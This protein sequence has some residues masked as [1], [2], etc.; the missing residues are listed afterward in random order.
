MR[1]PKQASRCSRRSD[2]FSLV[3]LLVV[4]TVIAILAALILAAGNGVFA[5]GKRSRAAGEISAMSSAA[6][7]YKNDNAVYPQS[8]G[9]LTTNSP[10]TTFDGATSGDEYQI[11]SGLLYLALTGQTNFITPPLP[12]VKIYMSFKVNQI[13]NPSGT[14]TTYSYIQ[15]PWTHSYGYS[16]GSATAPPYSGNGFFD[17]WSTGGSTATSP[18]TN[19]WVTSWLQ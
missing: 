15:D 9:N 11:N 4:M 16:T 8:D 19:V 7:G 3:E 5:S 6:E 10:Y 18:N 12:G 17:L 14:S 2:S 13:G 1:K